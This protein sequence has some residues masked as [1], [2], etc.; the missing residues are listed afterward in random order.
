MIQQQIYDALLLKRQLLT[1]VVGQVLLGLLQ[2]E[3]NCV[4]LL[5]S[6]G[7][8]LVLSVDLFTHLSN[9]TVVLLSQH[10][11]RALMG[12]VGLVELHLELG[13]LLLAPRVEGDLGG[14]VAASLLKLLVQLIKLSAKSAAALVSPGTRDAFSLKLLIKLLKS[15]LQFLDLG[16]QLP[17]QGLLILHLPIEGAVLLLLALEHLPHLDLVPLKVSDRLLGELQV[18]LHLPLQL[19]DVPLLLL[20]ALPGVLHLVEALLKPDLQLVEVVA[21]VL[22]GLNLLFLL[23]L[24]LRDGFLLLVELV[25]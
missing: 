13:K 10:G 6:L 1:L 3:S 23:H 11:Q 7:L 22:E 15:G 8:G 5:L 14:G 18:A 12:D 20:L 16:V 21:L 9:G 25:D 17:T 4:P 2:L 24:A 19:L